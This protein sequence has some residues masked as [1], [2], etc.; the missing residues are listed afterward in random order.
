MSFFSLF[1]RKEMMSKFKIT[2]RLMVRN[3]MVYS[4][5]CFMK[6]VLG[7]CNTFGAKIKSYEYRDYSYEVTI[8]LICKESDLPYIVEELTKVSSVISLDK[9]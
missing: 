2:F 1:K 8:K 6:D 4:N 7:L 5:S 9:L 3:N